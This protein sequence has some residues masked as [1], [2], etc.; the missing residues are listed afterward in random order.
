MGLE[1]KNRM[2]NPTKDIKSTLDKETNEEEIKEMSS[3]EIGKES[4]VAEENIKEISSF[5]KIME[6]KKC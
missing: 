2:K 5:G 4:K 3:S 6:A 1:Y